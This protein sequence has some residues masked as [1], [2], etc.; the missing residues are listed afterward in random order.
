ME[1]PSGVESPKWFQT[2]L[3]RFLPSIFFVLHDQPSF[4][5]SFRPSFL[6]PLFLSFI[7]SSL[8]SPG[9]GSGKMAMLASAMAGHLVV[10]DR[11][12]RPPPY[13]SLPFALL[14]YFLFTTCLFSLH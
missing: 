1:L 8:S 14:P 9:T 4:L 11:K 3:G 7:P 10:D 12:V 13:P 2:H 5:P 6:L